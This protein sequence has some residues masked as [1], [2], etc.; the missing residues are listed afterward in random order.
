[1][2]II[3]VF[4]LERRIILRE[5]AAC[6]Y[7]TTSAYLSKSIS[8][9]PLAALASL[10]FSLPV[11][12]LIG[13]RPSFGHYIIFLVITQCLVL[14]A[15][16]LGMLIGSSVPNV[17]MAQVFGPLVVVCFVIFGGNFA[18]QESITPVLRWIQWYVLL[19]CYDIWW[20]WL[21]KN[22]FY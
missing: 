22:F 9:W 8:Q 21:L 11:Y 3:T 10:V 14:A 7:H 6:S 16:S 4:P 12:W 15:Q 5:R 19:W 1:M 18:N 20:K 2:P 17:Q 13:L